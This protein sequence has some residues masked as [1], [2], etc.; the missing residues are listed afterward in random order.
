MAS[1]PHPVPVICEVPPP[2][3]D[4]GPD[5][6]AEEEDNEGD[7]T[8]LTATSG[9]CTLDIPSRSRH[10]SYSSSG[11]NESRS[12]LQYR[13]KEEEIFLYY[14]FIKLGTTEVE[15]VSLDTSGLGQ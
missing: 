5:Q 1:C 15:V 14:N 10:D 4:S 7:D 11:V 12:Q 9:M 13:I 3:P 6:E 2:D 8:L